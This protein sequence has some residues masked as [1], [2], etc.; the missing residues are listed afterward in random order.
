MGL[1][2]ENRIHPRVLAGFE[3]EVILA[4][5]QRISVTTANISLAGVM[6]DVNQKDFERILK[7]RII[8]DVPVEVDVEFKLPEANDTTLLVN[9]HCRTVYVRR[10]SQDQYYI[11][12]K[13]LKINHRFEKAIQDFIQHHLE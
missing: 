1:N 9:S 3:T 12:F 6:I 13:F 2:N 10:I 5:G 11:G 4:D 7:K 8:L